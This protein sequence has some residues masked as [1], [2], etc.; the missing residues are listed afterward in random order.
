MRTA[1]AGSPSRTWQSGGDLVSG[2]RVDAGGER[3]GG[4]LEGVVYGSLEAA[5]FDRLVI[6]GVVYELR[7]IQLWPLPPPGV[8]APAAEIRR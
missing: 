6:N 5:V 7:A 3:V 2:G 4:I 1:S 8:P